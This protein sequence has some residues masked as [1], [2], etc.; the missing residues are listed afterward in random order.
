MH[1]AESLHLSTDPVKP[2]VITAAG[3]FDATSMSHVPDWAKGPTDKTITI[4]EWAL[5]DMGANF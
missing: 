3:T 5:D 1:W 4:P 2:V